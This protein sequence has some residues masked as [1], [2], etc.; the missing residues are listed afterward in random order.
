MTETW[1]RRSALALLGSGAALVAWGSGGFT[2]TTAFRNAELDTVDD[3]DAL[4]GIDGTGAETTPTFENNTAHDMDVTLNSDDDVEFDVDDNGEFEESVT[5]SLAASELR[6]VALRGSVDEA[7]VEI[8]ATLSRDE[9]HIGRIELSRTYEVPQ[10]ADI[11]DVVGETRSVG[12]S[13]KYRFGLTNQGSRQVTIDGIGV[14]STSNP[15]AAQVGGGNDEIVILESTGESIVDQ[16]IEVGGSVVDFTRDDSEDTVDLPPE[17][18]ILFEF[19]RFREEG[20]GG[21]SQVSV[22]EVDAKLRA[23]DGSTAVVKLRG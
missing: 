5:F 13:G 23:E 20:G 8:E 18:E 19:D 12:E 17:E 15:N 14:P 11:S 10:A 4:L 9:E 22:E 7:D 21:G 3:P 16:I 1:T 2:S 6:E